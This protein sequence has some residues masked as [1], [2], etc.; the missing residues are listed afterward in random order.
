MPQMDE[1]AN[2]AGKLEKEGVKSQDE[3]LAD[4]ESND[5]VD[6]SESDKNGSKT[7]QTPLWDQDE[8]MDPN[9]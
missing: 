6:E 7:S 9:D 2:D 3:G 5:F 8:E 1:H 4:Y